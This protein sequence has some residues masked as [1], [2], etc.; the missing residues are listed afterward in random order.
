MMHNAEGDAPLKQAW[1]RFALYDA[2]AV[3]Q[4]AV[5]NQL[6][7]W[8]LILGVLGTSLALT[9]TQLRLH[10]PQTSGAEASLPIRLLHYPVVIIPVAVSVLIAAANRF[11]L[12]SKWVLLRG[13]A[14][15]I[16]R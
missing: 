14:E 1:E 16:K 13:G 3:R 9:Q 12:G 4:R 5:F 2:N 11:K 15:V 10:A 7:L 8:V 6:L